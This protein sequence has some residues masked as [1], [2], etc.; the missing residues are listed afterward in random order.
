MKTTTTTERVQIIERR[1]AVTVTVDGVKAAE[2]F[3]FIV[4]YN[5]AAGREETVE[6]MSHAT[7]MHQAMEIALRLRRSAGV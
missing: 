3:E 2:L 4:R 1:G 6:I 5:V 7:A